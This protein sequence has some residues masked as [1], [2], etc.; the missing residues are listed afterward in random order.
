[1]DN[2]IKQCV[3][4]LYAKYGSLYAAGVAMGVGQNTMYHIQQHNRCTTQVLTLMLGALGWKMVIV[5]DPAEYEREKENRRIHAE[6]QAEAEKDAKA[7]TT[8]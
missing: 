1:M 4:A 7:D 3:A 5:T 2:L 8:A 6:R